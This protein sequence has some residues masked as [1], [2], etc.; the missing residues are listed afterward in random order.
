MAKEIKDKKAYNERIAKLKSDASVSVEE[1]L[2][3]TSEELTGDR[4]YARKFKTLYVKIRKV[5]V[6]LQK[7]K[8]V[9]EMTNEE[10]YNTAVETIN[11]ILNE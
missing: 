4:V 9:K 8:A 2:N 10:I 1:L 6:L 11:N 7:K 3:Q 5:L